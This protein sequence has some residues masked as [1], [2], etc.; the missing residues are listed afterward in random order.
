MSASPYSNSRLGDSM[1]LCEEQEQIINEL[2]HFHWHQ[3]LITDVLTPTCKQILKHI[4][5][6]Y[7]YSE[8]CTLQR[9]T[10]PTRSSGL[11][12]VFASS[13]N[14]RVLIGFWIAM[15][16]WLVMSN[17][18]R[19]RVTDYLSHIK[20]L[21]NQCD[22]RVEDCFPGQIISSKWNNTMAMKWTWPLFESRLTAGSSWGSL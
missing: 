8:L 22:W 2:I 11:F 18:L 9:H 5:D 16:C 17:I 4:H 19:Q 6:S 10:S 7:S 13:M 20:H 15:R 1:E 3:T 14:F 21:L 12:T